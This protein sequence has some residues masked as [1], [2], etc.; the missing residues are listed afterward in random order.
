MGK[1]AETGIGDEAQPA[2]SN[3]PAPSAISFRV[4]GIKVAPLSIVNKR[5]TP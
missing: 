5:K 1:F 4:L 2:S 3:A